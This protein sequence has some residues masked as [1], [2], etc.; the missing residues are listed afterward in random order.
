MKKIWLLTTLLTTATLLAWC[1]INL[2]INN[3]SEEPSLKDRVPG[4]VVLTGQFWSQ[5]ITWDKTLYYNDQYWIS[6]ILWESYKSW[7]VH[8]EDGENFSTLTF[9]IKDE[10]AKKEETYI[11]WYRDISTIYI[12]PSEKNDEFISNNKWSWTEDLGKNTKYYF[13]EEDTDLWKD[14]KYAK[15]NIVFDIK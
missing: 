10:T 6:F 2:N 3:A 7:F 4:A 15:D 9:F 12:V 8:Q 14:R 1:S 11:D 5:D 13:Y